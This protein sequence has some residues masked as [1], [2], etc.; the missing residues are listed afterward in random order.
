MNW[1]AVMWFLVQMDKLLH[2]TEKLK[3]SKIISSFGIRFK[4][5]A[6]KCKARYSCESFDSQLIEIHK[7]DFDAF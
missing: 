1:K 2:K 3:K 6:E 5:A 7:H 4:E